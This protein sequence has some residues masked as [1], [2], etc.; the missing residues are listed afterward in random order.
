[1]GNGVNIL[2][3]VS[4]LAYS[5]ERLALDFLT[6]LYITLLKALGVLNDFIL[7]VSSATAKLFIT[8]RS[9]LVMYVPLVSKCAIQSNS[10]VFKCLY[11]GWM[12]TILRECGYFS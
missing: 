6:C 2:A 5:K 3:S 8:L 4:R 7:M 10:S 12:C 11:F 1:M 9:P